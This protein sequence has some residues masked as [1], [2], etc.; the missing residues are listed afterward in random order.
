[1]QVN[2]GLANG[3]QQELIDE[4]RRR[5][6]LFERAVGRFGEDTREERI[7]W[8]FALLLAA[9][10]KRG[11]GACCFVLDKTR[12]TAAAAAVLLALVR[13]QDEFPELVKNYAQTALHRG[14]RVK[15]KP[16]DYVYEY[17]G[18]WKDIR[19]FSD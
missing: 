2:S 5:F 1:M 10:T 19:I 3:E 12:G 18:L 16:S 15:V 11:P 6:P 8:F 14:Q 13:L 9:A 17:S 7:P 4:L